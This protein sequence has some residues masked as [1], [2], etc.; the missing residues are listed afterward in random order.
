MRK[1]TLELSMIVKNGAATFARCLG[2]VRGVVDEIVIG[3]TGSDDRSIAIARE[4]GAR[5]L[6]VPWRNDFAHA[7]N[8]VLEEGRADWVLVLDADEMLDPVTATA[9]PALLGRV[10]MAAYKVARWNYVHTLTSR[11]G[12]SPAIPNPNRVTAARPYA[13]YVPCVNVRLFRRCPEIRFESKVHEEVGDLRRKGLEVG[14]AGFIIHHFGLVEDAPEERDRKYEL[15]HRLGQEKIRENPSDAWAHFELG[16]SELEHFRNAAA[17]LPWFER[18][19]QLNPQVAIAWTFAGICRVRLGLLAEALGNFDHAARLG[20]HDAVLLE[21]TGDAHYHLE[22][23]PAAKACYERARENGGVSA[24]VEGKLG[25]CEIRLGL[26]ERGLRRLEHAITREP[27]FLELYDMLAAA[28]LLL[29]RSVLAVE[30][31]ERRLAMCAPGTD[32]Y[33][34]AASLCADIGEMARDSCGVMVTEE[35]GIG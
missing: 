17:A 29:G 19:I 2:S 24:L 8:A 21:A 34:Q 15:Y 18:A 35:Q 1:P 16:L 3:D 33:V 6:E 23:F 20:A 11:F 12:D 25:V 26:G 31:A 30:T 13:A 27:E 22:N 10:E 4:H 32:E 5:I 9:I 28:A 14:R 7:R